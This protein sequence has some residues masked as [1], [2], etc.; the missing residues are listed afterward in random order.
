VQHREHYV[1]KKETAEY[2]ISAGLRACRRRA[3]PVRRAVHGV[4]QV[5]TT[6]TSTLAHVQQF[7][8]ASITETTETLVGRADVECHIMR[9]GIIV[10]QATAKEII[11]EDVETV[12]RFGAEFR[13][14]ESYVSALSLMAPVFELPLS[15]VMVVDG[16]KAVLG[17]RVPRVPRRSRLP[18]MSRG[19]PKTSR[20]VK[21]TGTRSFSRPT[22][23]VTLLSVTS[24][25]KTRRS[26]RSGLSTTRGHGDSQNSTSPVVQSLCTMPA[27]T[28]SFRFGKGH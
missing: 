28:F 5:E 1:W 9:A 2:L 8:V 7:A 10:E 15:D 17:C 18:P 6:A 14:N 4:Q 25:S 23:G 24:C 22:A 11:H 12:R 3:V 20:S 26:T 13:R 16:G 21:P 19:T 27:A